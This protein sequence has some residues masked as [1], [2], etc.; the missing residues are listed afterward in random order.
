MDQVA[1]NTA[2]RPERGNAAV[3]TTG[4]HLHEKTGLVGHNTEGNAPDAQ[5]DFI[6]EQIVGV[7]N[8][9]EYLITDSADPPADWTNAAKVSGKKI[10]ISAGIPEAGAASKYIHIRHKNS[11]FTKTI[12]LPARPALTVS[13]G[14][15]DLWDSWTVNNIVNEYEEGYV[16]RGFSYRI[17]NGDDKDNLSGLTLFLPI[18]PGTTLTF[19]QRATATSF[20]SAE[21]SDTSPTR[22]PKPSVAIDFVNEKLGTSAAMDYR[23]GEAD[24]WTSCTPDMPFTAFG[25]NGAEAVIVQFRNT[26]TAENYASEAQRLTIPARH[27]ST[28]R[29]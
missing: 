24:D 6:K 28:S 14:T 13:L 27:K 10:R 11:S 4:A 8:R 7:S 26:F 12:E 20:K 5:L 19:W 3:E 23:L 16:P 17:D 21:I 25:W 22:L 9:M 1:A 29:V 18:K 15:G 2:P